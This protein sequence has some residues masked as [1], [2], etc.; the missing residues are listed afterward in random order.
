MDQTRNAA[1][2]PHCIAEG[3]SPSSKLNGAGQ[4]VVEDRATL[5][6]MIR[7]QIEYYFSDE[8]LPNDKF[9]LKQLQSDK[10]H[11]GWVSLQLVANF[12]KMKR[13]TSNSL[14]IREAIAHSELV[15]LSPNGLRI[16]RKI[17]FMSGSNS[18]KRTIYVSKLPKNCDKESITLVFSEFGTVVRVDLPVDKN[19]G[20][21]KGIAFVEYATEEQ[22]QRALKD[23]SANPKNKMIIKPFK[24]KAKENPTD[25]KEPALSVV[26]HAEN[27]QKVSPHKDSNGTKSGSVKENHVN[28][29]H[30]NEGHKVNGQHKTN[31]KSKDKGTKDKKDS[32]KTKD[33][34]EQRGKEP[35]GREVPNSPDVVYD[36]QEAW[37]RSRKNSGTPRVDNSLLEWDPLLTKSTSQRPKLSFQKGKMDSGSPHFVPV[38]NPVGPALDGFRGFSAGR[39]KEFS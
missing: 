31:G 4:L 33:N 8:N 9:L 17:P 18:D 2:M 26:P 21:H 13:L 1:L 15:V 30:T 6:D 38:R 19:T 5:L 20:E 28:G 29:D 7:R 10:S 34:S 11:E 3:A 14:D 27:A 16:K 22:A 37:S 32:P 24:P 25:G 36:G 39:G 12:N 23:F 35:V